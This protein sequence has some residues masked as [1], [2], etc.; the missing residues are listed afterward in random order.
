MNEELNLPPISK[1]F[2]EFNFPKYNKIQIDKI[3]IYLFED[4]TQPLINFKIIYKSGASKYSTPGLAYFS[5]Q[6]LT[7]GTKQLTAMQI[8][9]MT[10]SL[11]SHFSVNTNHDDFTLTYVSLNDY[12]ANAIEMSFDCLQDSVFREDEISRLKKKQISSIEQELADSNYLCELA[13]NT[14]L[15]EGTNY[16]FPIIGTID[17][18]KGIERNDCLRWHSDLVSHYLPSIIL[19]GCFKFDEVINMFQNQKSV[20]IFYPNLIEKNENFP[21]NDDLHIQNDIKANNNKRIKVAVINKEDA[22]QTTLRI[23]YKTINRNHPDYPL[24]QLVNVIF[25]GYFHSRLNLLLREKHGYTYGIHSSL[26]NKISHS[27][28]SV[29][30]NLN[31]QSTAHSVE[32]ILQELQNVQQLPVNEEELKIAKQYMIGSF[33]RSIESIQGISQL[34][35]TI[36]LFNLPEDYFT[37]FFNI[38]KNANCEELFKVQKKYFSTDT[39]TLSAS[40]DVQYLEKELRQFGPVKIYNKNGIIIE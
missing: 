14:A 9:D 7:R 37:I 26:E 21:T 39:L 34:L 11:G 25:G 20:S 27:I 12:L 6:M 10:D 33:L 5:S 16:Q 31:T 3:N 36:E 30:S 2:P 23:G 38:I 32:L 19:T 40:G 29:S 35:R 28:L 22:A 24:L 18:I 17:S 8:A 13:F 15:Y 1:E 4:K